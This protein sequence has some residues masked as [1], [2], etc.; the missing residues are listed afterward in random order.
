[1]YEENNFPNYF[2]LYFEIQ[3][4]GSKANTIFKE[5]D[6]FVSE[7]HGENRENVYSVNNCR[8]K[9]LKLEEIS[10]LFKPVTGWGVNFF[11]FS[12]FQCEFPQYFVFCNTHG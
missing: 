12:A 2:F 11:S 4:S 3:Y 6:S 7:I 9:S 10:V 1:M 8:S 5:H